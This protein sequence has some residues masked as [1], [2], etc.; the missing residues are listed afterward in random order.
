MPSSEESKKLIES[1]LREASREYY[2][3]DI[4]SRDDIVR[5][6]KELNQAVQPA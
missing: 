5:K 1:D 3:I 6:W 4:I 2:V